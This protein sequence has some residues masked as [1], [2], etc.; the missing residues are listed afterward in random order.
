MNNFY[1]EFKKYQIPTNDVE[2]LDWLIK[3]DPSSTKEGWNFYK[4]CIFSSIEFARTDAPLEN[5]F[6]QITGKYCTTFDEKEAQCLDFQGNYH[7]YPAVGIS[8]FL[9]C[10]K[11]LL[12]FINDED[13]SIIEQVRDF[14]KE[15]TFLN[16]VEFYQSKINSVGISFKITE[17]TFSHLFAKTAIETLRKTILCVALKE[18]NKILY[19]ISFKEEEIEKINQ[20]MKFL[21]DLNINTKTKENRQILKYYGITGLTKHKRKKKLK[22]ILDDYKSKIVEAQTEIANHQKEI[23]N[24]IIDEEIKKNIE[25][26]L[27]TARDTINT[28]NKDY[29]NVVESLIL[30]EEPYLQSIIKMIQTRKDIT[31]LD[32]HF[33]SDKLLM[34]LN[35][36]LPQ[37]TVK[38]FANEA[39]SNA[40]IFQHLFSNEIIMETNLEKLSQNIRKL[41]IQSNLTS[42]NELTLAY[43]NITLSDNNGYISGAHLTKE[44]ISIQMKKLAERFNTVQQINDI[45]EYVEKCSDIFHDYIRLHPYTDGN[46]RCSRMLLQ[47][48]LAKKGIYL[49]SLYDTHYDCLRDYIPGTFRY[50]CNLAK[51]TNDNRDIITYICDRVNS[52]YPHLLRHKSDLNK[53]QSSMSY[54]FN[55]NENQLAP[56]GYEFDY[57]STY[58]YGDEKT[59]HVRR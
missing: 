3:G 17:E 33:L 42:E 57:N 10:E 31:F 47:V 7:T 49:P 15:F 36:G 20:N 26:M 9:P 53:K 14:A 19:N 43:R 51:I 25:E 5:I 56:S 59:S 50:C 21:E 16:A 30:L 6:Y 48:M 8:K 13:L 45:T 11:E 29:M 12:D 27:I 39:R 40:Y 2:L 18:K 4:R 28:E 46:G 35:R 23:D 24:Y 34:T 54:S 38:E 1:D 58:D 44:E 55:P 37:Q 22:K 52:F 32:C 41:M